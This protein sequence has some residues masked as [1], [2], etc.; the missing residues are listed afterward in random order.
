VDEDCEEKHLLTA[1]P[2]LLLLHLLEVATVT[3]NPVFPTSVIKIF[4]PQS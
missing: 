2:Y 3:A 4:S 1:F